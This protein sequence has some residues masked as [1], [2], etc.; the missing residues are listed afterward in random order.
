[1]AEGGGRERERGAHEVSNG[2]TK[3]SGLGQRAREAGMVLTLISSSGLGLLRALQPLH[4]LV[5]LLQGVC[6]SWLG[7]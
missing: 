2:A 3:D 7:P 6:E 5:Q 1:V 4:A